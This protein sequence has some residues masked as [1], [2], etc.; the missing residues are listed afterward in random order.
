MRD[1]FLVFL[2]TLASGMIGT[3]V[4]LGVRSLREEE[5]CMTVILALFLLGAG[6]SLLV[7]VGHQVGVTVPHLGW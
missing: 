7:A 6:S 4:W 3:A 1:T 5:G 2:M